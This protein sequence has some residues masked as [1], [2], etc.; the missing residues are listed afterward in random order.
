M[1]E[2]REMNEEKRLLYRS[3]GHNNP[4]LFKCTRNYREMNVYLGSDLVTT[5][6]GLNVNDF[7]HFI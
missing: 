1:A 5:L 2:S 6:S 4:R 7:T 3:F